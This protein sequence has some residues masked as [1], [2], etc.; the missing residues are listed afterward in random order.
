VGDVFGLKLT[1]FEELGCVAAVGV[2]C[3]KTGSLSFVASTETLLL[4][5]EDSPNIENIDLVTGLDSLLIEGFD[6][7]F[8]VEVLIGEIGAEANTSLV[9]L[10]IGGFVPALML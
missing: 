9:A 8:P 1:V 7:T 10:E 5:F 6:E 2:C 4:S 3:C